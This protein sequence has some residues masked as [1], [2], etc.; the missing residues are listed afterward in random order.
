MRKLTYIQAIN[1]AYHEELQRDPTIFIMGEDIG[2]YWGGPFGE[3]KGL[4]E[5]FGFDILFSI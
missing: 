2:E 3:F 4:F 5:K 1:E